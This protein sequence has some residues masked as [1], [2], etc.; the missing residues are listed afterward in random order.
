MN[1]N[2]PLTATFHNIRFVSASMNLADTHKHIIYTWTRRYVGFS[3]ATVAKGVCL[4]SV[5]YGAGK[6]D[7]RHKLTTFM[8]RNPPNG[9][10]EGGV[11][12]KAKK[13]ES[14]GGEEEDSPDENGT[15]NS[16]SQVVPHHV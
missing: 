9:P 15:S 10:H 14:Q 7:M 8:L 6:L 12:K 13:T 1:V 4:H 5:L 3:T 11:E 2:I 16:V